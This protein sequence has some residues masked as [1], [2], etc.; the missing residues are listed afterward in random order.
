[1]WKDSRDNKLS[2]PSVDYQVMGDNSLLEII[3]FFTE[4]ILDFLKYFPII[5]QTQKRMKEIKRLENCC[6]V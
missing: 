6:N 5:F 3:A 1:M 4:S 2:K